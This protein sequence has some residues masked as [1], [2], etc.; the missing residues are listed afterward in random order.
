MA[1]AGS[2]AR[3]SGCELPVVINSGSGNQG[4]TVTVPLAVYAEEKKLP[5]EQLLR[6]L[7]LSNLLAI[8]QRSGIGCLSAYCGAVNAGIA[9][10]CGIA[11]LDGGDFADIAHT[12]VNGLAIVSGIICDGA[13][14]SC[15][16]KIAVSV[17]AGLLGYE[18]YR[19]GQQFYRGDG[20]VKGGVDLTIDAVARLGRDGMRETDREIL[21]IMI[22]D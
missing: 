10:A 1:A 16:S 12:L 20:I 14:A 2:D 8:Y 6:A 9:A 5:R 4:I 22:G 19:N 3:M 18:M 15:A 21:H 7:V 17:D 13:K 11:F